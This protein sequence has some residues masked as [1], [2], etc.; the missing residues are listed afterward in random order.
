MLARPRDQVTIRAPSLFRVSLGAPSSRSMARCDFPSGRRSSSDSR[1]RRRGA[2]TKSPARPA[3][4]ITA[5][6]AKNTIS[7]LSIC[8]TCCASRGVFGYG[9]SFQFTRATAAI[10]PPAIVARVEIAV[11]AVLRMA[12]RPSGRVCHRNSD[13]P[14]RPATALL[15]LVVSHAGGRDASWTGGYARADDRATN[16]RRPTPRAGAGRSGGRGCRPR[17]LRMRR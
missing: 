15:G 13:G 2:K 6:K 12:E 14:R 16:L 8:A 10:P 11:T 9:W 7:S 4:A 17:L 3:T 1:N 5:P